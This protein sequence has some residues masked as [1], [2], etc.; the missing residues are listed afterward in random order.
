MASLNNLDKDVMVL[1][2]TYIMNK[3]MPVLYMSHDDDE[4]GGSIW[5]FHCDNGD[6]DMGKMLLVKL[7]SILKL[8]T[9]LSKIE[10]EIGQEARRTSVLSDWVISEQV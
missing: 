5:Q 1:T 2:S 3:G 7:G 10:L 6:Y 9:N 8:D 4:E